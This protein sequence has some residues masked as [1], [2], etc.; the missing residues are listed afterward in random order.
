M[1]DL[2]LEYVSDFE[3]SSSDDDNDAPLLNRVCEL[4]KD[5]SKLKIE[6]SYSLALSLDDLPSA[7]AEISDQTSKNS[8]D[9][10]PVDG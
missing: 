9:S 4:R 10:P 3:E 8:S 1:S 2:Y 5:Q 7:L 6:Y